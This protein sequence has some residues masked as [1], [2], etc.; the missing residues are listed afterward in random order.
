MKTVKLISAIVAALAISSTSYATIYTGSV[1]SDAFVTVKGYDLA[2][3]SPC[4]SGLNGQASCGPID[5]SVQ[6]GNG[7]NV[8]TSTL[9]NVLGITASTFAVNYSSANTQSWGGLNY[10][11]ATGWF[12]NSYTHIDVQDGIAGLWSFANV[13]DSISYA[14]TI[15]YRTNNNAPI[16]APATGAL[17][18]TGLG[19]IGFTARRRRTL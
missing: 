9:F 13:P 18:L 19:L 3:A 10:A 14:E 5:L 1:A 15:V 6:S 8:M 17:L 4:S 2:W 11:K 12:S 16:P 7:W